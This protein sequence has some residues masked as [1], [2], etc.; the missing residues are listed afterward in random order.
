MN[1]SHLVFVEPPEDIDE[2]WSHG[3]MLGGMCGYDNESLAR[4][5]FGAAGMVIDA[6]LASTARGQDSIGPLLYLY[7][8]GIELYLKVLTGSQAPTHSIENLFRS[9]CASVKKDFDTDV[10]EWLSRP[11]NQFAEFDPASD[12]FRYGRTMKPEHGQRLSRGGEYWVDLQSLRR[13]MDNVER[14]FQRVLV[15][16]RE[17]LEGLRRLGPGPRDSLS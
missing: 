17:G 16:Q 5:Y 4:S 6:V 8:H 14:S 10:P 2:T 12:L 11:I 7:R 1:A 13:S 3:A 9:F 15:A